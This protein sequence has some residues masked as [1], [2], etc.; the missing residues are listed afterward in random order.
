[1]VRLSLSWI[2][3]R[4]DR[5]PGIHRI[6]GIFLRYMRLVTNR[7][8]C[9][10]RWLYET[11]DRKYH[12]LSGRT[13]FKRYN[14]G[15][16]VFFSQL[17]FVNSNVPNMWK[18]LIFFNDVSYFAVFRW[19][20]VSPLNSVKLVRHNLQYLWWRLN[21]LLFCEVSYFI[22]ILFIWGVAAN[23]SFRGKDHWH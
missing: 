12:S 17:R 8:P 3:C 9:T 11:L 21:K 4:I 22:S 23:L 15:L 5:V 6:R 20:P 10:I 18:F 14:Y 13:L 16:S 2:L 1:M 19:Y 7:R